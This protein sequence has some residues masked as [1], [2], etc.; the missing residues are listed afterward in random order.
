MSLHLFLF[1]LWSLIPSQYD[2]LLFRDADVTP[3][4]QYA[5]TK[6]RYHQTVCTSPLLADKHQPSRPLT[7]LQRTMVTVTT[8]LARP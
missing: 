4:Q 8:R 1:Q 7:L 2:V 6:V 3:E 5:L